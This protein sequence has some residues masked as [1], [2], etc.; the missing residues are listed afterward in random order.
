MD[1]WVKEIRSVHTV[2]TCR[3]KEGNLPV[4]DDMNGSGVH[5]SK[6]DTVGTEAKSGL[7][8]RSWRNLSSSR[9][10]SR[11]DGGLGLEK[12]ETVDTKFQTEE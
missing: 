3:S 5:S 10:Y 1:E 9:D 4:C 2:D 8:S 12:Q 6:C 11:A 7:I